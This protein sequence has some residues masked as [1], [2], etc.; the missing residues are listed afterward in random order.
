MALCSPL[1]GDEDVRVYCTPCDRQ[2]S[3][4]KGA[5]NYIGLID[6]ATTF[7]D[8]SSAQ[9][10]ATKLANGNIKLLPELVGELGEPET[11]TNRLSA[12]RAEEITDEVTSLT[13]QIF[14]FDNAAF[15]DFDMEYDLKNKIAS[16]TM[17][18]VDCNNILY[19]RYDWAP[20]QN[21]GFGNLVSTVSR[22]FPTDG[23]QSLNLS[24]KFNTFR[25][26]FKGIQMSAALASVISSACAE[27]SS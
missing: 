6:C 12:C 24:I 20:G 15:T 26:G 7:N 1:C 3:L 16:K 21:P 13:A 11:T 9:E 10:W 17:F 18:F 5:I 22:Q 8:I 2:Q 27:A 23:L 25:T 19:Y 4:R 14:L